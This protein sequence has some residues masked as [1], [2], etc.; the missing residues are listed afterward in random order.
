MKILQVVH[1]FPP[2]AIG[3][4][5]N[6]TYWLSEELS[7]KHSVR[8]FYPVF[9]GRR[10]FLSSFEMNGF[11]CYELNMPNTLLER[12][13][14]NIILEATYLNRA[15]E[16]DFRKILDRENPDIVHFQHLV[17]LSASLIEIVA[18]KGIPSVLTLH[19]FWLI[20]PRIQLL[21]YEYRICENWN[22][23]QSCFECWNKGQ[24]ELITD[25]LAEFTIPNFFRRAWKSALMMLNG[26]KKF[27][28][29]K[30]Y[31][32]SLLLKV[33]KIVAPSEF[34]RQVFIK[35][36]VPS[37]KIIRLIN[38][39][40]LSVFKGFRK[41]NRKK[42]KLIFGF[43]GGIYRH[44]G[45][46]VLVE[47]FNRV[48]EKN[49]ELRI[50][51]NF[52]PN[53]SYY[54]GLKAKVKN[55]N[56]RFMGSFEDVKEPYSKIDI[57]IFPSI[58]YENCP[59]VLQEASITRTPVIASNVGAIPEFVHDGENGLLFEMGNAND[60]YEKI[61]LLINHHELIEYFRRNAL[62][63]KTIK[64]HANELETIYE[65]LVK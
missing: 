4:T 2:K 8:V 59:L 3:G 36:G 6:Y 48:I 16:E 26:K 28:K 41:K 11:K 12:I 20:C 57:L 38:G 46:D 14:R 10:H 1:G 65:E 39:Y 56:I 18:K 63:V 29:R 35:Y 50:Y 15:V 55:T 62:P 45:V 47:A 23:A 60:L 27:E 54:K 42:K 34:T 24:V 5:E 19:D 51:G 58:W 9:K 37:N 22:G 43:V 17:S 33:N 40:D 21:T 44:K 32:K 25:Y 7:K 30:E 53:S 52:D 31:M 13:R 49:V 61:N 64:E